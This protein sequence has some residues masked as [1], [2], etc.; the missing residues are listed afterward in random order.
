MTL[1]REP[2][3][4]IYAILAALNAVQWPTISM[5]TWAHIMVTMLTAALAALVN[6]SL[7]TPTDVTGNKGR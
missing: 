2:T 7:V 1:G 4:I 5:P 3:L 6:R